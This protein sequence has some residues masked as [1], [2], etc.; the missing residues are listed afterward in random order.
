MPKPP[1]IE[2]PTNRHAVIA[3]VM[4]A[5]L[6]GSLMLTWVLTGVTWL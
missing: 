6:L 4:G 3:V 1:L 2:S 5:V